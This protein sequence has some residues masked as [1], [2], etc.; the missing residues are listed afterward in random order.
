M[1][2]IITIEMSYKLAKLNFSHVVL[3]LLHIVSQDSI[4]IAQW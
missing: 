3:H 1:C 4:I 2:E